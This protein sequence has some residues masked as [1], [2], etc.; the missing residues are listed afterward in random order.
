MP[1]FRLDIFCRIVDNFGD[2]GVC[3]RLARQLVEEYPVEVRLWIDQPSTLQKICSALKTD[4]E[5]QHVAGVTVLR[6]SVVFPD[7]DPASL[8]DVVVEGFGCRLPDNY[9]SAMASRQSP[10]VW[11]NMEYLSAES[12]VCDCHGM[13]SPQSSL[14]LTRHFF[15]PGFTPQTGGLFR[16]ATLIARRDAFRE[17]T[18][19]QQLFL[20]KLGIENRAECTLSLF[21]Y[22]HA[23]VTSLFDMLARQQKKTVLC[24][25]PEGVAGASV[26]AFLG[27]SPVAG[28]RRTEGALTV[29]VVPLVDQDDYDRL[30]WTCDLNFV[31]GEDSFLRAQWAARPFIWQIYP[32]D[33]EAHVPK[34]EAFCVRYFPEMPENLKE[35]VRHVWDG[36]NGIGKKDANAMHALRDMISQDLPT[37]E[38]YGRKWEKALAEMEDFASSLF[39]FI[40]SMR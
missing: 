4:Q 37:L 1:A 10:P 20:K 29:Q 31:R 14:P 13:A 22:N 40:N 8:P 18:N 26:G 38:E 6:W 5:E 9:L 33:K 12:W 2:A 3:W 30:L 16:E 19:A 28:N 25:V 27:Q 17:D 36:W 23:P 39:R 21:C 11:I 34:L 15:F 7:I 24:L 32:Q 35:R